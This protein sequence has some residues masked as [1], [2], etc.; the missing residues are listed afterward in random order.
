MHVAVCERQLVKHQPSLHDDTDTPIVL[1]EI[2]CETEYGLQKNATNSAPLCPF[3]T[4]SRAS[5]STRI[6]YLGNHFRRIAGTRSTSIT[7]G[8]TVAKPRFLTIE[9]SKSAGRC[10]VMQ[11]IAEALNMGLDT[12]APAIGED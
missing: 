5:R 1:G 12:L 9:A 6:G 4:A 7:E 8:A 10:D 11:R 2:F 3:I